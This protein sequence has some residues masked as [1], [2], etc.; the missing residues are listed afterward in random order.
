MPLS[1]APVPVVTLHKEKHYPLRNSDLQ[2]G[3]SPDPL[4]KGGKA[5]RAEAERLLRSTRKAWQIAAETKAAHEADRRRVYERLDRLLRAQDFMAKE[6]MALRD[7][8]KKLTQLS[9]K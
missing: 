6:F 3:Y 2:P 1:G 8:V 7:E 4:P 5:L 9:K